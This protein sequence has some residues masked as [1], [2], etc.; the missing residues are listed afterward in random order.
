MPNSSYGSLM[1]MSPHWAPYLSTQSSAGGTVW[2]G[3]GGA[4]L[5]EEECHWGGFSEVKTFPPLSPSCLW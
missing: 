4:A 1:G 2:G 5:L 3:L